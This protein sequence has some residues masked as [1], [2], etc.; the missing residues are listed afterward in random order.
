MSKINKI[1]EM[2][3]DRTDDIILL[4]TAVTEKVAK[5]GKPYCELTL[6]DGEDEIT[7]VFYK[8]QRKTH[9]QCCPRRRGHNGSRNRSY[10]GAG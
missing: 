9:V 1:S 4:L 2:S 8:D 10:T 5:N 6:S 7:I 3:L